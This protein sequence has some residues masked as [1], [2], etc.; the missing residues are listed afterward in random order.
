MM[1]SAGVVAAKEKL[2]LASLMYHSRNIG[3]PFDVHPDL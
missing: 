2:L 1:V 3:T